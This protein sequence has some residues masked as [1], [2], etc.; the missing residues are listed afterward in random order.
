MPSQ[1]PRVSI[2]IRAFNEEKHL[3]N[4][5][6]AIKRQTFQDYEIILVDSGSTDSTLAIAARFPVMVEHIKPSD[7]TFGRSL[8]TGLRNARGEVAV[9]V[10]A[11][12]M[13]LGN[14]WL[15]KLI[16]PFIEQAVALA[17]GK[18]RGGAGSKFSENQHFR[19][20]F[21]DHSDL[22]QQH[23]YCNNANLALRI[24]IWQ[25]QPFD[26][27]LTGL[28]DLAWSSALRERGY[29]IA[30]VAEAGVAHLHDESARQIMNRHRREA[31]ALKRILPKSRFTFWNFASLLT[32]STLSD[33]RAALRQRV[34]L[35]EAAGI[36]SFRF[37][38]YVGTYRGYRDP[39][40]P[41][42]ALKQVF[43]YP[44]GSLEKRN[45]TS[46]NSMKGVRRK[47]AKV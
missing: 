27:T 28:E 2:V 31:I 33:W 30:Y 38:Q 29:K 26:E 8:N 35:R 45:P 13:P 14:D 5:L 24:S 1:D 9:I 43:Y 15:E 6:E 16:S 4:L 46:G 18:Q 22:D 3:G 12:I 11:H 10:S 25:E 37:F 41:G 36:V 21:P 17:Y 39:L 42:L 32:R 20:W 44:P 34:F 19:R 7:F 23:A 47:S 40:D